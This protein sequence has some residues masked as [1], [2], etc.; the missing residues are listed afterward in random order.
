MKT[1]TVEVNGVIVNVGEEEAA[2]K[3]AKNAKAVKADD[4]KPIEHKEADAKDK[5]K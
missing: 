1:E 5:A 4:P 3:F 2:A